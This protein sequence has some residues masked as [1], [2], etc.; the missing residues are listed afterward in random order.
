[1]K[2]RRSWFSKIEKG[3]GRGRTEAMRG[4]T[5]DCIFGEVK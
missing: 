5:D 2:G 3:K 1:M 4:M